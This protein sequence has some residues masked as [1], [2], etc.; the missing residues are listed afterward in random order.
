M[1]DLYG[2]TEG[3]NWRE[4]A[5]M[6][7]VQGD[8]DEICV[9]TKKFLIA[10]LPDA[11]DKIVETVIAKPELSGQDFEYLERISSKVNPLQRDKI[12]KKLKE[13]SLI[14]DFAA[15]NELYDTLK[16][17]NLPVFVNG[18]NS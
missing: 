8:N 2:G 16:T 4:F 3:T 1:F 5:D 7:L 17:Y 11:W 14:K 15:W 18:W 12:R 9:S 10:D 6:L 13:V